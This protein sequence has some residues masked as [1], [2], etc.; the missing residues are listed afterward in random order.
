[1]LK[2]RKP[3]KLAEELFCQELAFL[4]KGGVSLVEALEILKNPAEINIALSKPPEKIIQEAFVI[5]ETQKIPLVKMLLKSKNG[6]ITK[7][8]KYKKQEAL[9]MT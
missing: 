8:K 4:L 1:M 7:E 3:S 9:I 6:L 2:V 5:Y